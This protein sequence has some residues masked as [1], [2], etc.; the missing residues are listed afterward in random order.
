MDS[1]LSLELVNVTILI[2]VKRSNFRGFL[3][4]KSKIQIFRT[5]ENSLQHRKKAQ[6]ENFPGSLALLIKIL[7]IV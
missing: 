4:R 3:R 6:F 7:K 5:M 1:Q 2:M